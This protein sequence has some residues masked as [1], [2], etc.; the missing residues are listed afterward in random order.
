MHFYFIGI[1]G[2]GMS[3]LAN[4]L[5]DLGHKVSGADYNKKYFTEATFRKEIIVEDFE[6]CILNESY[7]YIIGNAFKVFDLTNE[8]KENKYQYAFYNEFIEEFFK[9][10]KIG[11]C[12]SHG[13]TTTTSFTSQL[14]GKKINALIGDGSGFG[15]KDSEYLLLEA[16]EYQNNFLKYT[17]DYLVIL[18]IDYDHP[19]FF[20]NNNEYL[21]AFMKAS[22]QS[23][24]VIINYDDHNC[25]KIVHKNLISFG[26]SNQADIVL[27]IREGK[28]LIKIED[29]TFEIPLSFYGKHMAYNL[30]AAFII[31]YFI[32][33]DPVKTIKKVTHLKLPA[34]RF[35]EQKVKNNCVLISDY[36]HHPTEIKACI[37]SMRLKYPNH[38]VVVIYQGHTHSR[39]ATFLN[40][41]VESLKNADKVYIMPTF[42]SVRETD[43]DPLVLF[44]SCKDFNLYEESEIFNEIENEKVVVGF[45][46]AGDIYNEFIFLLK[47][48]NY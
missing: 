36:A 14:I 2:T 42:S 37:D 33:H 30:A 29:E 38:K 44:H 34:R 43:N 28:L 25:R 1:K 17:Y 39:T 3:S 8:I 16:C 4:I 41:Y 10:E 40:E 22:L 23:K 13:K 45:L 31:A 47:K 15:N 18:N 5:V 11:V 21:Y 46:G 27:R 20:K 9:M 24:I 7:F 48:V 32:D 6:N 12:G 19:D 35:Y 26:F